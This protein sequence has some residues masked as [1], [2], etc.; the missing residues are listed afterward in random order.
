[1]IL[2]SASGNCFLFLDKG[3]IRVLFAYDL[4]KADVCNYEILL[5]QFGESGIIMEE[6][7]CNVKRLLQ[8]KG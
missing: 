3:R 2:L 8:E 4:E 1:M 5:R 6:K 7:A